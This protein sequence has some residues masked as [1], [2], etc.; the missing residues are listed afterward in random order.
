[1]LYLCNT[2]R[3][4]FTLIVSVL[5]ATSVVA[6]DDL[7]SK[8][9]TEMLKPGTPAPAIMVQRNGSEVNLLND[10]KGKYVL[11]EFWASWCG[12]CRHDMAQ[13]RR[14]NNTFA[15]DSIMLQGY[16]FD[17]TRE[18]YEKCRTDSLL[19]W[20]QEMSTVTMRE[21]PV[22]KDYHVNWIPSYYLINKEGRIILGTVMLDKIEAYLREL[23]GKHF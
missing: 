9:A 10:A 22:A 13:M 17:R 8:Y 14:I 18:A 4:F 3:K 1:M 19:T 2:M 21:S 23:T 16:S 6:Q 20:A 11:L 5:C 7:D 12:D 15:S